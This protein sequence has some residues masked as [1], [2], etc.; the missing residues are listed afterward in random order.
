MVRS[1]ARQRV[2][3]STLNTKSGWSFELHGG[4]REDTRILFCRG[5]RLH[6]LTGVKSVSRLDWRVCCAWVIS[7]TKGV[8][9]IVF[10][11]LPYYFFST[12]S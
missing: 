3:I 10:V 1:E 2:S 6:S 4:F 11:F 7:L 8:V 9:F 5:R 12:I